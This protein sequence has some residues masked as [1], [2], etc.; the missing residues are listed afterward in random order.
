MI[1]ELTNLDDLEKQLD[2]WIEVTKTA[3][4][5][6]KAKTP[7]ELLTRHRC[8]T[9][10]TKRMARLL[11]KAKKE[12]AQAKKQAAKQ[13]QPDTGLFIASAP[14][15]SLV[16]SIMHGG[17]ISSGQVQESA[18]QGATGGQAGGAELSLKPDALT[19]GQTLFGSIF[20]EPGP[21]YAVGWLQG[22]GYA[23]FRKR[24]PYRKPS[25]LVK[26]GDKARIV[27][28]GD[29]ATGHERAQHIARMMHKC[30]EDAAKDQDCHAVH[31]GDIYFSGLPDEC[32][33]RFLQYW[34]SQP[35]SKVKHWCINGNH[36]MYCDG[37]G[38]FQVVLA[39]PRFAAQRYSS[40]FAFGNDR[41]QFIGLDTAYEEWRLTSK[42]TGDQVKW[43]TDL[44]EQA[45][46]AKRVLLS[47]HQPWSD[48]EG[49]TPKKAGTVAA[50][51]APLMADGKT[52][53]W[54]WGHEH[55][56]AIYNPLQPAGWANKLPFGS[57]IGHSGVPC[58]PTKK[59]GKNT[60]HVLTD[61]LGEIPGNFGETYGLMGFAVIDVDGDQAEIRYYHE[62][63]PDMQSPHFTA[64]L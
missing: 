33:N 44:I 55:R 3:E 64:L 31:L 37:D 59:A 57:C 21:G 8:D 14:N 46:N 39:N 48:Y 62:N 7:R 19:P 32:A 53:A 29:W 1:R 35:A 40:N 22:V 51:A 30:L 47:H 26:I 16:Q 58:K 52:A 20:D 13:K 23:M 17:Y 50:D 38:Y 41:W 10:G 34:P 27:I 56:C 6:L 60:R 54:L 15:L 5:E 61:A 11:A 28:A 45:P 12:I 18:A 2:L 25:P 42:E 63:D 43:A 24:Q 49:N 4:A 9:A 36:D